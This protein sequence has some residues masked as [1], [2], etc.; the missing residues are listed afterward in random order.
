MSLEFKGENEIQEVL[1]FSDSG[2]RIHAQEINPFVGL[3]PHS[4]ITF[5]PSFRLCFQVGTQVGGDTRLSR[6]RVIEE[7]SVV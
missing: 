4:L 6:V 2:D 7:S 3:C 5:L 1:S